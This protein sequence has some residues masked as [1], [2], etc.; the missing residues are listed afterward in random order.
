MD[1][2]NRS[3]RHQAQLSR[4]PARK[5]RYRPTKNRLCSWSAGGRMARMESTKTR[6]TINLDPIIWRPE[7]RVLATIFGIGLIL[8]PFLSFGAI[9]MFDAPIQSRGDLLHRTS[10]AYFI[11]FYPLTY[12][13]TLLA[14]HSLR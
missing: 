2:L 8:W 3:H 4:R 5:V 9:F 14:Y 10:L 13:A 11:W 12:A 7:G 6:F 1:H